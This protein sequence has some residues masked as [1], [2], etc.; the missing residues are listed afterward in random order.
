MLSVIMDNT[1]KKILYQTPPV[2][3]WDSASSFFLKNM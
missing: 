3:A 2:D 1:K